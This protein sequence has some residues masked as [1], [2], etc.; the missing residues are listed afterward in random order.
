MTPLCELGKKHGTDKVM[1]GY[2]VFYH[3]LFGPRRESIKKVVEIGIGWPEGMAHMPGYKFGASL[4]MWRDYFPNAQV[5]G[6]DNHP[7]SLFTE[8]RIQTRLC[9]QNVTEECHKVGR[10]IGDDI[11][12]LVDD[13]CHEWHS[14]L[15]AFNN[16]W[17][18]VRP[19][20]L[21][22]IEDVRLK[23]WEPLNAHMGTPHHTITGP[24]IDN[25]QDRFIVVLK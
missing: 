20:G 22:V 2:T 13:G 1:G 19:G 7:G 5:W 25:R 4:R 10:E 6:L 14:Q 12:L 17:R 15:N 24:L 23:S 11:D 9:D 16:L 21:Y 8:D 3:T 18:F